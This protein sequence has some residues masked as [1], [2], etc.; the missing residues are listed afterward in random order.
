MTGFLAAF[1]LLLP[2]AVQALSVGPWEQVT[3]GTNGEP[4]N[5]SS[6][7]VYL[8]E[9]GRYAAFESWATNWS[10]PGYANS[11]TDIFLR[12]RVTGETRQI[13]KSY[14]GGPTDEDSFDPVLSADGRYVAFFSYATNLVPDD[15]NRDDWSRNGLDLFIYDALLD[16]L[17]RVSVTAD[18]EQIENNSVGAMTPDGQIALIISSGTAIL[19]DDPNPDGWPAIY[20]REW[21]TGH[22]ERITF[23]LDGEYPN[24]P[25]VHVWGS[26]DGSRIVF[27]SDASN[28]VPNDNNGE[29]DIF[30][31]ERSNG[32][33]RR[34]SVAADGTEGN[35]RSGQPQ[36]TPDGRYVVF[37]SHATNLVP[38]DHNDASDIFLYDVESGALRRVSVSAA[39]AEANGQSTD[40]AICGDGR[41]IAFSSD[42]TN[43]IEGD[44]NNERDVF[45]LEPATGEIQLIS[46][47]FDGALS[48][49][50]A[51]RSYIAPDCR[52]I[53]FASD[54]TNL[55][56][57]DD[58]GWR[59]IFAASIELPALLSGWLAAPPTI[60][61]ES[62]LPVT[63]TLRNDDLIPLQVTAKYSVPAGVSY[64][65][66]SATGGATFAA[67]MVTWHGEIAAG[68][69]QSFSFSLAV[70][71]D[72]PT[73]YA[74]NHQVTLSGDVETSLE[75]LTIVN[76]L[77]QFLP[78]IASQD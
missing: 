5:G 31:Y 27:S 74:V 68:S 64:V 45:L 38:D 59:D 13:T 51:H 49:G 57:G 4:G 2:G 34:I 54:A 39:G 73:A 53:A 19:P 24:G 55:V 60:P 48:N 23:G 17:E 77:A 52:T 56:L 9:D 71:D 15:T 32:E 72:P 11:W 6:F 16:R 67:G 28:L 25:F 29:L 69:S 14:T 12:D 26:Y 8:S 65:P 37:R 63:V 43:L 50:R 58:G 22:M 18:G 20:W 47:G 10:D 35:G 70:P 1:T 3:V 33:T 36:I 42:A 21:Q 75:A 41:L 61:S 7:F 62:E 30:L 40:G 44:H 66:G 76:G 46:R 78:L